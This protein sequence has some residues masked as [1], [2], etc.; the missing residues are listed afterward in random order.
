MPVR[1]LHKNYSGAKF[2]P[3]S[4]K[5]FFIQ[6]IMQRDKPGPRA[7]PATATATTTASLALFKDPEGCPFI[8]MFQHRGGGVEEL[9]LNSPDPS[10]S[11]LGTIQLVQ[12]ILHVAPRDNEITFRKQ[13]KRLFKHKSQEETNPKR[14]CPPGGELGHALAGALLVAVGVGHLPGLPHVVLQVL[15][16]GLLSCT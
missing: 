11:K 6:K 2:H 9:K 4:T 16:R 12:S 1:L 15:G 14:H 13:I 3:H 8:A 10:S 5:G 7:R